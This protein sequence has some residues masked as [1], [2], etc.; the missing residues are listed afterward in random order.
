MNT[1][2]L[3]LSLRNP[4]KLKVS[5]KKLEDCEKCVYIFDPYVLTPFSN[6]FINLNFSIMNRTQESKNSMFL[7]VQDFVTS[8]DPVILALMPDF[9]PTYAQYETEVKYLQDCLREQKSYLRGY[10]E[11]KDEHKEKMADS[12]FFVSQRVKSYAW[13]IGDSVLMRKASKTKVGILRLADTIASAY[14]DEIIQHATT[15]LAA[16]APYGVDAA[17]M[18][19]LQDTMTAFN[20]WLPKTRSSIVNR[21]YFTDEIRKV[22]KNIDGLLFGLDTMVLTLESLHAEFVKNYFDSRIIV[23]NG[24]RKLSLRGVVVDE[25]GLPILKATVKLPTL[26]ITTQTTAKGMFELRGIKGGLYPVTVEQFGFE[27]H[28]EVVAIVSNERTDIKVTL[29]AAAD[30]AVAS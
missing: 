9:A 7:V 11:E 13:A 3:L 1:D 29:K 18:T 12:V 17:A 25:M 4:Q 14:A 5:E 24:Y 8:S 15:H 23:N 22:I 19:R 10:R 2:V 6:P 21:K 30:V 26:D 28:K 27:S 20:E 16:L